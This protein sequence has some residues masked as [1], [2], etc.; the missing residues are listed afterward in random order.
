MAHLSYISRHGQLT[1]EDEH[2]ELHDKQDGLDTVHDLWAYGYET[3]PAQ[4]Q[5]REAINIVL[6]MPEGTEPRAVR[7]A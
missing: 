1:L 2:G 5:S 6:S 7:D 3:M 4:S